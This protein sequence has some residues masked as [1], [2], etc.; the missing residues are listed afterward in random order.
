MRIVS[1][2]INAFG[3]HSVSEIIN[4]YY[5]EMRQLELNS[6]WIQF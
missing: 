3:M 6:K 5:Y 2:L 1:S 4:Y